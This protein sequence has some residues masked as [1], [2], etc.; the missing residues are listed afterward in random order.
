MKTS[1]LEEWL[2]TC[3]EFDESLIKQN[4]CLDLCSM[5]N[6]YMDERGISRAE[7]IRRLNIDRNYGYQLLNGTRIPTRNHLIQIGLLLGLDTER[8]QRLLKT[9][10]KK[11]LYVRDLFD[12]KVFY[13]VKHKMDFEKAME[14]IWS[15]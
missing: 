7:L 4:G 8:F 12:A 15:E 2:S 5:I 6:G 3:E 10:E 14:F 13:A 11:P 1:Q 9:A